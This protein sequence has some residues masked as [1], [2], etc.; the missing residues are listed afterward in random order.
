MISHNLNIDE[1]HIEYSKLFVL[2]FKDT[3]NIRKFELTF[4]IKPDT[5][6]EICGIKDTF[7]FQ[8]KIYSSGKELNSI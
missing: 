1:S 8:T 4:S 2:Y 5:K 3:V 7:R 6:L